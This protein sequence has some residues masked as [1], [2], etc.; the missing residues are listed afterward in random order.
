MTEKEGVAFVR[1]GYSRGDAAQM[2]RFIGIGM[3][4]KPKGRDTLGIATSWG[5][6]PDKS[7]RNQI[8]SEI[9]YQVQVTQNL[10]FTPSLQLIFKP[11]YTL[12]TKWVAVP[13]F[14]T[15]FTF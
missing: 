12:E 10:T 4:F 15:R 2:R 8:T 11:S 6:P 9:F 14:R 5:S 7:L 3:S 1:A 13:G